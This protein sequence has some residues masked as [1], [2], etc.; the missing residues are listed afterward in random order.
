MGR[1][2]EL[3]ISGLEEQRGALSTACERAC[4]VVRNTCNLEAVPEGLHA[5]AV[6]MAAGEF[7][8]QMRCSGQL[9]DF[10]AAAAVKSLKEG[11]TQVVYSVQDSEVPLDALIRQLR[12]GELR[13]LTAFRRVSW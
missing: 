10:D 3:G 5:V 2:R 9:S 1:L 4:W 13:Q 12:F 7:L 6:D 8:F 11:D